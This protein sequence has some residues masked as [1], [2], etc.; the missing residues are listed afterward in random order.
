MFV[1]Y[2]IANMASVA[3]RGIDIHLANYQNFRLVLMAIVFTL[4]TYP[5]GF[6]L[7]RGRNVWYV[8]ALLAGALGSLH[9]IVF[10]WQHVISNKIAQQAVLMQFIFWFVGGAAAYLAARAAGSVREFRLG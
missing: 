6:S 2:C 10:G 4:L 7:F 5:I 3:S 1:F 8:V 9:Y